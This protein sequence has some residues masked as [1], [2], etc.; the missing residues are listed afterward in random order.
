MEI[1]HAG[2]AWLCSD[3]S[4]PESVNAE[5]ARAD[6]GPKEGQTQTSLRSGRSVQHYCGM[7]RGVMAVVNG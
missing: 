6:L 2:S 3:G 4:G 7:C 1:S 5:V